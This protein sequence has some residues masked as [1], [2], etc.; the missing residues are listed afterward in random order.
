MY[1]VLLE[2]KLD[3]PMAGQGPSQ[4]DRLALIPSVHN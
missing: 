1:A 2:W 4:G 3:P